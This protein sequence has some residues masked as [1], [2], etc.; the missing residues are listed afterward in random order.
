MKKSEYAVLPADTV[1]QRLKGCTEYKVDL[2]PVIRDVCVSRL[3]ISKTYGG[4]PQSVSP[5]LSPH[6]QQMHEYRGFMFVNL[7]LHPYGPQF[8]GHPGL[9]HDY[10]EG[11]DIHR[12]FSKVSGK[13]SLWEYMGQYILTRVQ[14]LT[15]HEWKSLGPQVRLA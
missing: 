2:D 6:F 12:V 3:F 13:P 4:N 7:E 8:P 15:G 1:L 11:P 5:D 9:F 14:P 10:H